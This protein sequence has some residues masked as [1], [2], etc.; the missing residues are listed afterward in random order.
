MTES[1]KILIFG[2]SGL[3]GEALTRGLR[4][5]GLTVTPIARRF[6][7]SQRRAFP[8]AIETNFMDLHEEGL[9]A[10]VED[11][12]MIVNCV[13]LLQSSAREHADQVH[14]VFVVRLLVVCGAIATP[15]LLVHLSI[16][17]NPSEDATEFARTKRAADA[18]IRASSLPHVIL[19]PGFVIAPAAFGGSAMMRAFASLPFDV[20]AGLGNRPFFIT[21]VDDI[22]R[23]VAGLARRLQS[24]DTGF[25]EVWDVMSPE[26]LRFEEVLAGMRRWIGFSGKRIRLPAIAIS[27]GALAG[28]LAAQLGWRPPLRT[29]S[30]REIER[31]VAGDPSA[32]QTATGLDP[33][34]FSAALDLL[35]ATV[36]EKWFAK[37]YLAKALMIGAL[38]VFWL[39]SGLIALTVSYSAAKEVMTVRGLPDGLAAAVTIGGG[40]ADILIGLAIAF[41]RSCAAGLTAGIGVASLYLCGAALL[42]PDLWIDPLG[43]ILKTV[44]IIVLMLATLA[45][46]DER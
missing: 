3:I 39:L 27:L 13:G 6:T 38:S 42:L 43:S 4:R 32:W 9:R 36:Q 40:I 34:S 16:P 37:L 12:D 11:A 15:P 1:Q 18:A 5:E 14:E 33:T 29:T 17:G 10:L 19:R 31:G 8:G 30:V 41:R 26:P 22:T 7:A 20:P 44:P 24:G 21:A 46:L 35:P 23:T 45:L 2:A 28:D 25:A